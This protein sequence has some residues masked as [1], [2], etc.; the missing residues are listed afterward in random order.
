MRR[1]RCE[2][3]LDL[4]CAWVGR[5]I[6]APP[7]R[8]ASMAT[9]KA[10]GTSS[11]AKGSTR[12]R[13]TKRPAAAASARSDNAGSGTHAASARAASGD[14]SAPRASGLCFDMPK[15]PK[16]LT[17][18]Q[19]MEMYKANARMALDVINADFRGRACG[20]GLD[21]AP[22]PDQRRIFRLR[23]DRRQRAEAVPQWMQV[24]GFQLRDEVGALLLRCRPVRHIS[25]LTL[26]R[27]APRRRG[28]Q[29]S[30]YTI[31]AT[32]SPAFAGDDNGAWCIAC[33]RGR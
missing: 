4:T 17:P 20:E 22:A 6:L 24:R 18:E 5:S 9:R 12:R 7:L 23:L 19:A 2:A 27:H 28:I 3:A 13:A 25:R 8:G 16:L 29:Q 32:G 14:T 11:A 33:L 15:M 31:A 30:L 10:A 1:R 26:G 21:V